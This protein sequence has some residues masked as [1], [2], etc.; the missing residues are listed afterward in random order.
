MVK[1]IL[2]D[3]DDT[4]SVTSYKWTEMEKLYMWREGHKQIKPLSK[5]SYNISDSFSLNDEEMAKYKSYMLANFP[6]GDLEEV[7]G[8]DRAIRYLISK[9]YNITF[10]TNRNIL[11]HDITTAWVEKK[12]GITNPKIIFGVNDDYIKKLL[13]NFSYDILIDNRVNRCLIAQAAGI[14]PILFTGIDVDHTGVSS[15]ISYMALNGSIN[16]QEVLKI[17]NDSSK[18]SGEEEIKKNNL[19]IGDYVK[20]T[21]DSLFE[22][23]PKLPRELKDKYLRVIDLYRNPETGNLVRVSVT[24]EGVNNPKSK[25]NCF[26]IPGRFVKKETNSARKIPTK[27]EMDKCVSEASKTSY[28]YFISLNEGKGVR[29]IVPVIFRN[30]EKISNNHDW[31]YLRSIQG[32]QEFLVKKS[33]VFENNVELFDYI[34]N[35]E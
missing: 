20:I 3:I 24:C 22:R 27:M 16:Y 17:M 32:D 19:E 35:R 14:T 29:R 34:A 2:I 23:H 30:G 13:Q 26:Y 4:I 6:Y 8:A 10:I 25:Y 7:P 11:L 1:K 15:K 33:Q 12:I 21:S 5:S 18:T 9:G 28:I 31:V